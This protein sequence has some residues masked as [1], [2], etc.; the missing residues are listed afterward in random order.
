MLLFFLFNACTQ[1]LPP[2]A[3]N[4]SLCIPEDML[5]S[6][7]SNGVVEISGN[8][9]EI[10]EGSGSCAAEIVITDLEGIEYVV[11]YSIADADDNDATEIPSWENLSDVR[12]SIYTHMSFGYSSGVVLEDADGIMMA[13]EEGYWSG[14]LSS[15]DLPFSVEWS[16]HSVG[17]IDEDCSVTTGYLQKIGETYMSPFGVYDIEITDRDFS[18]VSI[19]AMKY[20]P[21]KNCSVS[22]M[23]DH[24]SWALFRKQ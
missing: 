21:G 12:L 7:M 16:E 24:F 6:S 10:R 14:G 11:G 19:A 18:F 17:S 15:A 3:G 20:G 5:S 23:S 2:V 13:L 1:N 4:L 8:L 9:Q 22:D